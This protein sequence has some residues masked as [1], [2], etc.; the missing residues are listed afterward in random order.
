MRETWGELQRWVGGSTSKGARRKVLFLKE[1]HLAGRVDLK[2]DSR[3]TFSQRDR[4]IEEWRQGTYLVPK[5]RD[6]LAVARRPVKPVLDETRQSPLP[7]RGLAV[8]LDDVQMGPIGTSAH[9][10][11]LGDDCV[12]ALREGV[13]EQRQGRLQREFRSAGCSRN[14]SAIGRCRTHLSS[15]ELGVAGQVKNV[16]DELRNGITSDPEEDVLSVLDEEET[17]SLEP[18]AR[19]VE[20]FGEDDTLL[21]NGSSLG[22]SQRQC[23]ISLGLQVRQCE[24]ARRTS[25]GMVCRA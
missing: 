25:S 23:K 15:R 22:E 2:V 19:E 13:I 10:S 18:L 4:K 9:L 14:L 7:E 24:P 6:E 8:L 12:D 20:R 16:H 11:R 17:V 1:R 21:A 3:G 5:G